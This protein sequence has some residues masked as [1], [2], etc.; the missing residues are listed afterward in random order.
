MTLQ[1]CFAFEEENQVCCLCVH[2]RAHTCEKEKHVPT[3]I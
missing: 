2:V 3:P 1:H